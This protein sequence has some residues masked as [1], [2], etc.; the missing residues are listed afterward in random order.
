VKETRT[1]P[2]AV[3]PARPQKPVVARFVNHVWM[4]DVTIVKS[5]LGL[6]E[7][8]VAGVFEAFSRA[9]LSLQVF[10]TKPKASDMVR[11]LKR[12]RRAFGQPKHL[13]TDLG[14]EFTARILAKSL[15][16]LGI[17]QRFTSSHNLYAT[18][19]GATPAEAF[20]GIEPAHHSAGSPPRERSRERLQSPPFTVEY[21]DQ[22]ERRF[23]I[24]QSVAQ[25]ADERAAAC[26][27]PSAR[28]ALFDLAA[29]S[30][31]IRLRLNLALDSGPTCR[32]QRPVARE[33]T[34]IAGLPGS[35]LPAAEAA[36]AGRAPAR[37]RAQRLTL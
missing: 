35:T 10:D 24:L 20:L 23:P 21:L 12:A 22:P 34:P 6:S 25:L 13:I 7:L 30:G 37:S 4:M 2:P 9:P 29:E 5:F 33:T 3:P 1:P 19:R 17:V 18:A 26:A 28:N 16:R 8:H 31:R 32:R 15:S 36:P 14:S 27:P 11:L